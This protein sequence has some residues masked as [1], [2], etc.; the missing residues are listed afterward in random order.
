MENIRQTLPKEEENKIDLSV[1]WKIFQ[2]KKFFLIIP[3]VLSMIVSFVGVRYL[4]PVYEASTV[5]SLEQRNV[6]SQTM[7]QYLQTFEENQRARD[8]QFRSVMETRLL[9]TNFLE[10]VIRDL[11]LQWSPGIRMAVEN[12]ISPESEYSVD[13]LVMKRLIGMLRDKIVV[14]S[15]V[16]GFYMISVSDADPNSAYILSNKVT[17]K[18]IQITQESKLQGLRQAGAFSN[19]QIAIYKEKMEASEKELARVRKEL[20]STD[21]ESNPINSANLHLAEARKTTLLSEEERSN[22]TLKRIRSRL[23]NIFGLVPSTDKVGADETLGIIENQISAKSDER[24]LAIIRGVDE[25]PGFDDG[26]D[27]LWIELRNRISEII[28][29][30]YSN[31]S[32]EYRPLITEYYYQRYVL[33]HFQSRIRKLQG[34]IERHRQ[35]LTKRPQLERDVVRLNNEIETNR[36][37]YQAFLESKTSTQITEAVQSTNLGDNISIIEKAEKP[38]SPVEPDKIRIILM[39]VIFGIACGIGAILVTE[40]IDDSFRS[41]DEVEKVLKLSVLGTVPKTIARFSWEKKKRGRMIVI[42]SIVLVVFI[43]LISGA[44]FMY[45]KALDSNNIKVELNVNRDGG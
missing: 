21:I 30:E 18:Y 16:P 40:Y 14:K 37:V 45:A 11:N 9:S 1:Y 34:Y 39:S 31:F 3:V 24:F 28:Q 32:A 2:R 36:A 15:S 6:L 44:M 42:W 5:V 27:A 8:R 22:L 35:N 23:S 7:G 10:A 19:E 38:F 26:S 41:V 4:T 17:E 20:A 33:E 12:S 43:G 29:A 25:Q 13:E